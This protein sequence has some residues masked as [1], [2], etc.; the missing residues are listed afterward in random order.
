MHAALVGILKEQVRADR[1]TSLFPLC[2][3]AEAICNSLHY[4]V[5]ISP[6]PHL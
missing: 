3:S 2:I 1:F 4:S 6:L 5:P